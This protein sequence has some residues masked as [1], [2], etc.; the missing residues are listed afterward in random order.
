[1]AEPINAAIEK[2]LLDE[3]AAFGDDQELPVSYQ[4]ADFT[5]KPAATKTAESQWLRATVLPAPAIHT[6]IAYDAHVQHYGILQID[7]VQAAGGGTLA[8]SRTVAAIR[9]HFEMGL[10]LEQDGFEIT[11][12]PHSMRAVT[13]GP[14]MNDSDGWVKVPVSIPWLCFERPA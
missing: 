13:Q 5:D 10:V 3:A 7:V 6:G 9:A 1:M 14:L 2:A 8:M 11:I 4:N 12:S